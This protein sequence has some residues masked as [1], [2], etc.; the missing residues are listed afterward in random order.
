MMC[1]EPFSAPPFA[2]RCNPSFNT[3]KGESI[4]VLGCFLF[5]FENKICVL[6][7][8]IIFRCE[9]SLKCK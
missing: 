4:E 7:F 5:V 8:L 1:G 6:F 2:G 9:L 3:P